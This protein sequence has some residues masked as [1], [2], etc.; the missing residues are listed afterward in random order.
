MNKYILSVIPAVA[1]MLMCGCGNGHSIT[2]SNPSDMERN[3]EIVE[4]EARVLDSLMT[5][6][7]FRIV[8]PDGGE[9]PYQRTY[10][11]KLIFQATVAPMSS[12]VYSLA[13]GTPA[14]A[15]TLSCGAFYPRRKDDLTWEN[16]HC[17]YRAYGPA[18]E[19]SGEKA[20]GYDIWTKSV[21]APVVARRYEDAFAGIRNLHRDYGDGMD[22][23]TVGPTL[24]AGTM[25]LLDS[26]G[27][28]VYPA[29]F[30]NYEILD[31]GPLRF[32]VRLE[33]G[34]MAGPDVSEVRVIS[35]DAGEFLNRTRVCYGGLASGSR[36]AAGIVLHRQNPDGYALLP[37]EGIMAY[38]DLTDNETVGNG[39]IYIG[40]VVPQADTMGVSMLAEPEGD[41]LGHMLAKGSC[42]PDADITYY[43]GAGWSKG[44]MPDWQTWK[45]YLVGFRSRLDKPLAAQIR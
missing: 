5:G 43:W 45:D 29:C 20:Y 31:N 37:G 22:V 15:D 40:A 36:Y 11:G 41:A 32:T 7:P 13:E 24:G 19:Q 42:E 2:V 27:D 21:P 18:L 8:G 14:Q 23:Y 4:V 3:A 9:V 25:A 39:I 1:A 12:T 17:A 26:V 6:K 34:S 16:D 33:Y 38:A 35:L 44:S 28:I 10:D 30:R